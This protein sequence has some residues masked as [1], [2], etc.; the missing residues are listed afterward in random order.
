MVH[1]GVWDVTQVTTQLPDVV[2]CARIHQLQDQN[3]ALQQTIAALEEQ[4]AAQQKSTDLMVRTKSAE[5]ARLQAKVE[6]CECKVK[7]TVSGVQA[8]MHQRGRCSRG[9]CIRSNLCV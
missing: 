6:H 9:N 4:A 2:V 5:V 1:C 3:A 7:G 8:E